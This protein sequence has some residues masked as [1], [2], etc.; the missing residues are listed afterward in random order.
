MNPTFHLRTESKKGSG[1]C[2]RT[3]VL[4]SGQINMQHSAIFS[5]KFHAQIQKVLPEGVQ[6]C[7]HFY[8]ECREDPNNTKSGPSSARQRNA[9]IECWLGSLLIFSGSRPVLLINHKM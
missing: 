4:L 3:F 9:I 1:C 2:H 5:R 8:C 6:F 7:Q